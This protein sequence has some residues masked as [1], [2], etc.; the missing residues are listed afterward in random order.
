MSWFQK[1]SLHLLFKIRSSVDMVSLGTSALC[2]GKIGS[3]KIVAVLG[4][5]FVTVFLL[6]TANLHHEGSAESLP[7]FATH[8]DDAIHNGRLCKAETF[9]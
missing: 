3:H 1:A 2:G 7:S 8:L 4:I 9:V 6:M 5:D